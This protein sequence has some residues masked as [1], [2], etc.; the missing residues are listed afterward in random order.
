ME[1]LSGRSLD[2]LLTAIDRYGLAQLPTL[3]LRSINRP[4]RV[5][6]KSRVGRRIAPI[7]LVYNFQ[8]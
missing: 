2:P 8:I 1:I 7:L 6:Q 5:G 3:G 4:S